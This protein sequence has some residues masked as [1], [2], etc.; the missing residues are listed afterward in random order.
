LSAMAMNAPAQTIDVSSVVSNASGRPLHLDQVVGATLG[1]IAV[2]ANSLTFS[3]T[4]GNISY[5]DETLHYIVTDGEGHYAQASITF[6]LTPPAAPVLTDLQINYNGAFTTT[7]TCTDCDPSR[8]D[9]R[10]SING[11]PVGSNLPTYQPVG[12]EAVSPAQVGVEVTVKNAYCTAQNTGVSGGNACQT[13]RG[14]T[15]IT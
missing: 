11:I 9:Y 1:S 5:G 14:K 8:T 13:V 2:N 7:L 12:N 4:P 15:V 6:S 3:Y 10:Y